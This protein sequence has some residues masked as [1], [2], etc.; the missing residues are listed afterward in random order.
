VDTETE[1]VKH[2]ADAFLNGETPHRETPDGMESFITETVERLAVSLRIAIRETFNAGQ[3]R[4][5]S[6]DDIPHW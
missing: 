2:E 1:Y 4:E 6:S 3:L 5:R